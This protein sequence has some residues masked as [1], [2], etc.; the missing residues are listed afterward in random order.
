MARRKTAKRSASRSEGIEFR[1]LAALVYMHAAVSAGKETR[2]TPADAYAMADE[3]IEAR[4]EED[5]EDDDAEED[6]DDGR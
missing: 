3:L 6:D 2:A 5:E 4:D 1:D